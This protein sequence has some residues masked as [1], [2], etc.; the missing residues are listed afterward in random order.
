MCPRHALRL[1][2][3]VLGN[4]GPA[5]RAAPWLTRAESR[6]R[7]CGCVPSA[8]RSRSALQALPRDMHVEVLDPVELKGNASAVE[9]FAVERTQHLQGTARR[10]SQSPVPHLA[11]RTR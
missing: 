4:R 10:P 2:R 6:L 9:L 3:A 1:L 5:L 8:A 11:R 7:D